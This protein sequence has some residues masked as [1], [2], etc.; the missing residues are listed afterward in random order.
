MARK[1][2]ETMSAKPKITNFGNHLLVDLNEFKDKGFSVDHVQWG[3]ADGT[4]IVT[5]RFEGLPA[6]GIHLEAKEE[7]CPES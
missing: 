5:F 2:I 1:T 7:T 6:N 4:L 3:A